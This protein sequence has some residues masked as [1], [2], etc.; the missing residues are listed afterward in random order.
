MGEN[1]AGKSTLVKILSGA[2]QPDEGPSTSGWTG[3]CVRVEVPRS[4]R[5]GVSPSSTRSCR[6][7]PISVLPTIS[8]SV[9]AYRVVV[10]WH[11]APCAPRVVPI[12]ERVASRMTSIARWWRTSPWAASSWSRS[13]VP[14]IGSASSSWMSPPWPFRPSCGAVRARPLASRRPACRPLH[15]ATCSTRS[16]RAR[17]TDVTDPRATAGDGRSGARQSRY[18][19]GADTIVRLDGRP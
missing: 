6:W 13:P 5:G 16:I 18:I 9:Q 14:C 12:L 15:H 4:S 3:G 7:L 17:R 8:I 1:G 10:C 2:Y 19:D 11:P